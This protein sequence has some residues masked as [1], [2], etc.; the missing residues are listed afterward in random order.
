MSGGT[1]IGRRS[2]INSEATQS[3]LGILA[4]LASPSP[5]AKSRSS[6][7]VIGSSTPSVLVPPASSVTALSSAQKSLSENRGIL[8]PQL[9]MDSRRSSLGSKSGSASPPYSPSTRAAQ[10]RDKKDNSQGPGGSM[11]SIDSRRGSIEESETADRPGS[12]NG[13]NSN[14][15]SAV[16]AGP[17]ASAIAK[18]PN[19]PS[20]IPATQ[21]DVLALVTATSPPMPSRRKWMAHS[22]PKPAFSR[23]N[24]NVTPAKRQLHPQPTKLPTENDDSGSDT[25]SEDEQT[26]RSYSAQLRTRYQSMRMRPLPGSTAS[27]ALGISGAAAGAGPSSAHTVRSRPIYSA[28]DDRRQQAMSARVSRTARRLIRAKAPASKSNTKGSDDSDGDTTET[29]EELASHAATPTPRRNITP[30]YQI[31]PLSDIPGTAG[32]AAVPN[33]RAYVTPVRGAQP[34]SREHVA[35]LVFPGQADQRQPSAA[36]SRLI[37]SEQNRL[38]AQPISPSLGSVFESSRLLPATE[39]V[40]RRRARRRQREDVS[41]FN[42]ARQLSGLAE[43]GENDEDSGGLGPRR[44]SRESSI[45]LSPSPSPSRRQRLRAR[46]ARARKAAKHTGSETETDTELASRLPGSETETDKSLSTQ[47]TNGVASLSSS[48][49]NSRASEAGSRPALAQRRDTAHSSASGDTTDSAEMSFFSTR[50]YTTVRR[51]YGGS[52]QSRLQPPS[53]TNEGQPVARPARSP[54]GVLPPSYMQLPAQQQPTTPEPRRPAAMHGHELRYEYAR[55]GRDSRESDGE[56]TE[57]DEEFFGPSHAVHYSIRPPRRVIRHLASL[58]ARHPQ[59]TALDLQHKGA[60]PLPAEQGGLSSQLNAGPRPPLPPQPLDRSRLAAPLQSAPSANETTREPRTAPA[61]SASTG[62]GLGLGLSMSSGNGGA[63]G[64]PRTSS[65]PSL[66]ARPAISSA[67]RATASSVPRHLR[68]PAQQQQQPQHREINTNPLRNSSLRREFSR[69]PFAPMA[70]DLTF[71]GTAL[72]RLEKAHARP[73]GDAQGPSSSRKR[74]LTAPSLLE[75]PSGKRTQSS[76]SG[77]AIEPAQLLLE[78]EEENGG[79][80]PRRSN[81]PTDR[82]QK[83]QGPRS[84]NVSLSGVSPVSSLR[85]SLFTSGGHTLSHPQS[86]DSLQRVAPQSSSGESSSGRDATEAVVSDDRGRSE[87]KEAP[88]ADIGSPSMDAALRREQRSRKRRHSSTSQP[89]IA[90]ESPPS[91]AHNAPLFGGEIETLPPA[92]TAEAAT[93]AAAG[94]D[95][96]SASTNTGGSPN[97]T[98]GDL[99]FPPINPSQHST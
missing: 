45:S 3:P 79:G 83:Q 33:Q 97:R 81:T 59:P 25:V 93:N 50:S 54:G 52:T 19:R 9:S 89:Y 23:G 67:M 15:D 64:P 91:A 82:R 71:K 98:S 39:P 84:S 6:S 20:A 43:E 28:L 22:T 17:G 85:S 92:S 73:S 27:S 58:R 38:N 18:S 69:D 46:R 66:A 24:Q 74:A 32:A 4:A 78:D 57:T 68:P 37:A 62:S 14:R 99:L 2:P 90:H 11:L 77:R 36:V 65:T 35:P 1:P 53:H 26:L 29:D 61:T 60:Q 7:F 13:A 16:S 94:T 34:S 86:L 51:P 48:S 72:R 21:L 30:N 56:T 96:Q 10:R 75:S 76:V 41:G 42:M 88:A 87:S 95:D 5:P 8:I 63:G 40:M 47:N 70:S 12:S 55:P 80:S 49:A 44:R 31:H